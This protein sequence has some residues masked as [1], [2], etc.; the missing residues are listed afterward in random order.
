MN[1]GAEYD[2]SMKNICLY[3]LGDVDFSGEIDTTDLAVLKKD[4]LGADST[5][6]F[7]DV[8]N[9]GNID[10]KDLVHL[11]KMFTK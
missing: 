10:I 3:T 2:I 8:N 11:K 6:Q 1:P 9:D 4:L 7:A 5:V